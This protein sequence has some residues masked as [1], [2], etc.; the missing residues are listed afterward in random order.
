[1]RRITKRSRRPLGKAQ[2]F[3]A[4][5]LDMLAMVTPEDIEQGKAHA[6]EYGSAIFVAMTEAERVE[7]DQENI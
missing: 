2:T 1:M 5:E 4:Q 3:T 7:D 6:R